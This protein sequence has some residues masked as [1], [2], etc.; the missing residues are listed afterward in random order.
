[1][2]ESCDHKFRV[3]KAFLKEPIIQFL[4]CTKCGLQFFGYDGTVGNPVVIHQMRKPMHEQQFK[5]ML[6]QTVDLKVKNGN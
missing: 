3:D 4:T 2:E 1:M 6:Y 5:D